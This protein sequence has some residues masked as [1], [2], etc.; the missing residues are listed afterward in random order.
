MIFRVVWLDDKNHH[1]LEMRV[2]ALEVQM[3]GLL[4]AHESIHRNSKKLPQDDAE[5]E[6]LMVGFLG[7]CREAVQLDFVIERSSLRRLSPI[8]SIRQYRKTRMS[9]V[10][11]LF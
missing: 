2:R 4:P 5:P 11:A 10:V 9:H 3:K 7:L 1:T 6:D 8:H